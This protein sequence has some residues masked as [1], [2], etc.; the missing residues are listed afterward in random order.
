[1]E[2]SN[3][4]QYVAIYNP[5]TKKEEEKQTAKIVVPI[6]SILAKNEQVASMKAVREIPEEYL[7]RLEQIDIIVRPF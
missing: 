1:M 2:K 6:T 4:F 3:L 5:S 7:D